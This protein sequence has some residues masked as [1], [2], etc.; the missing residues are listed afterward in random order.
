M[1]QYKEHMLRTK[2]NQIPVGVTATE[3]VWAVLVNA[4][5]AGTVILS[6]AR[7]SSGFSARIL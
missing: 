2:D 3:D 4:A 6:A 7:N 5:D 1:R